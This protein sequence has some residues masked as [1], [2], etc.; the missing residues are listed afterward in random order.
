MRQREPE[1]VGLPRSYR[2]AIA[3]IIR[4]LFH[5]A[6]ALREEIGSAVGGFDLVGQLVGEG[7]VSNLLGAVGI[8]RPSPW[9]TGKPC[10]VMLA[11]PSSRSSLVMV[12]SLMASCHH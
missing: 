11:K 3:Q 1:E 10:T 5:Q 8:R 7:L 12:M 6:A 2:G 4:P 9:K